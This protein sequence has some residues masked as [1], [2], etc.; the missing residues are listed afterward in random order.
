[1]KL[2]DPDCRRQRPCFGSL[3]DHAMQAGLVLRTG[4]SWWSVPIVQR[5]GSG[6]LTKPAWTNVKWSLMPIAEIIH[7]IDVYLSRLRQ[8]RNLLLGR[9]PGVPQGKHPR[10]KKKAPVKRADPTLSTPLRAEGNKTRSSRPLAHRKEQQKVGSPGTQVSGAVSSQTVKTEQLTKVEPERILPQGIVITRLPASRRT[11]SFRT[12]GHRS[13]KQAPRTNPGPV[14]P[15]T[16]LR[17]PTNARIVV[18]SAD[19]VKRE[20]A[21]AAQPV[22]RRPRIAPSGLSGRLAFEALFADSTDPSKG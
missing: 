11:R 12:V 15:A 13:A 2:H 1:M 19:Q 4:I 9:I 20:R 6:R 18:V 16:A 14:Q 5:G 10:R 21:Q 8:A 17:G 22:V 3:R 7:E